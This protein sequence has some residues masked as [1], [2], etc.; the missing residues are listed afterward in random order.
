MALSWRAAS[1]SSCT[2]LSSC[3][4]ISLEQQPG[5]SQAVA[6]CTKT[7]LCVGLAEDPGAPDYSSPQPPAD[8]GVLHILEW[9]DFHLLEADQRWS[10]LILLAAG[11]NQ[12][13]DLVRIIL[14]LPQIVL[15]LTQCNPRTSYLVL[16][17]VVLL[18]RNSPE[19]WA[20]GWGVEATVVVETIVIK[21]VFMAV[22]R[23]IFEKHKT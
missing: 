11:T 19:Y 7:A 3:P 23:H 15:L 13:Q 5:I 12:I 1:K 17:D 16:T 20:E 8:S 21:P 22:F 6:L 10:T 9:V 4:S 2:G 18:L 14:L